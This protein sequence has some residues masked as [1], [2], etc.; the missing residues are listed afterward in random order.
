MEEK[1]YQKT[2]EALQLAELLAKNKEVRRLIHIYLAERI[3]ERQEINNA[4]HH[5][6]K[7]KLLKLFVEAGSE[8]VDKMVENGKLSKRWY[9]TD[10]GKFI[11]Y[12]RNP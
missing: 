7:K 2:K 3:K 6:S 11:Y 10:D 12:V 1:Q 9:Q 5:L 8:L 4:A